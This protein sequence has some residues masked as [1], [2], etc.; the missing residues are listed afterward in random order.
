MAKK[1]KFQVTTAAYSDIGIRRKANED[2]YFLSPEADLM[3]VCDGMGGQVAG[4]FASKIAVETIK[5][6]YYGI[7][8][9]QLQKVLLDIE[10]DLTDATAR[11]VAAVRMANRRLNKIAAQFPKLHGMGTTVVALAL[12]ENLAT[13]VHVGDSRIFRISGKNVL[14]LT[15]D[16]SWLNELIEDDEI[17][18]EQ[19]ETFQEKNVITRALGTSSTV[20][21]DVHCEK[22]RRNDVYV[23]STD[24]MHNSVPANDIYRIY[25]KQHYSV[26]SFTKALIEKAK[27]RDGSDNITVSVAKMNKDCEETSYIG[28]STT[29]SEENERVTQKEDKLLQDYYGNPKSTLM[30]KADMNDM[31]QNRFLVPAMVVL[32]GAIC[33]LLGMILQNANSKPVN[34]P[35]R[36]IA[37]YQ[38]PA[39]SR[40][41][42]EYQTDSKLGNNQT[43]IVRSGIREDAILALVFFNSLEDYQNTSLEKRADILD[44][45]QPYINEKSMINSD[46]SLFLIDSDNNVIRK[47]SGLKIPGL[48]T[49]AKEMAANKNRN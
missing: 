35:D 32:T 29:I 12:N 15:E 2:C 16:H 20:R 22:Y 4:G 48:D 46:F 13:M 36:T 9:S 27:K 18:E 30:K 19:I 6:V 23:L 40:N 24:G 17:N 7:Q 49:A 28:I 10:L 25:R 31:K 44:K 39:L 47:T 8:K 11:L 1:Q 41:Q 34:V 37:K 5:D 3:I 43:D 21:L 33:F 42:G 38:S 26:E 45:I 14:Q